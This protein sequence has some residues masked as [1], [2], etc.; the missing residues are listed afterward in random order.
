MCDKFVVHVCVAVIEGD[1]KVSNH[2]S[3]FYRGGSKGAVASGQ[4]R[5]ITASIVLE[6]SCEVDD[7]NSRGGFSGGLVGDKERAKDGG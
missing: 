3:L 1:A 6:D 5:T 4:P 7:G 2:D